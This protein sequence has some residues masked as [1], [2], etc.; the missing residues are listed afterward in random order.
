MSEIFVKISESLK[1]Q[2]QQDSIEIVGIVPISTHSDPMVRMKTI[3]DV[4]QDFDQNNSDNTQRFILQVK[5]MTPEPAQNQ[6]QIEKN[7]KTSDSDSIYNQQGKLNVPYLLQN[8]KLLFDA[9]DYPLARTIYNAILSSG[10][11]SA[12]YH[13]QIGCCLEAEGQLNEARLSYEESIAFSPTYEY[14]QRLASLLIRTNQDLEA[15]E[16]LER[17]LHLK[18]LSGEQK[19]DLHKSCG[20]CWTRANQLEAAER[21]YK[22]ALDFRPHADEIRSNL[23][24]IYLQSNRIQESR[25]HFQDAIASNPRNHQALAGL[26]SCA[27]RDGDKKGA[28]DYFCQSLQIELKNPSALF[29]LVKCAYELKSYATAANFLKEYIQTAPMN[30]NLLYSLAG[31]QFHLGRMEEAK[32]TTVKTLELQPSHAGAQELLGMIGKYSVTPAEK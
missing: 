22:K 4:L 29:Y 10:D 30:T 1:K 14:H 6:N 11:V 24:V 15:A 12:N 31:L 25:R 9:G 2:L 16:I 27:L 28:H 32:A 19:F 26:G 7:P 5:R 18:G 8:A 17:T 3:E 21:N 23:G 13:F 20:N